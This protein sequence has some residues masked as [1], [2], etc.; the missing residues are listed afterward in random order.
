MAEDYPPPIP[1]P[2]PD[3]FFQNA[4][5]KSKKKK[6][7]SYKTAKKVLKSAFVKACEYYLKRKQLLNE[8]DKAVLYALYKQATV[9]D[10][11]E[12]T[13]PVLKKIELQRQ[14]AWKARTGLSKKRAMELYVENIGK[15][16][17][18][19]EDRRFET[20]NEDKSLPRFNPSERIPSFKEMQ[21]LV[22]RKALGN[23]ISRSPRAHQ[24]SA[25]DRR[26]YQSSI[27]E[28]EYKRFTLVKMRMADS[29]G[30]VKSGVHLSAKL[31]DG[32]PNQP[33]RDIVPIIRN[34]VAQIVV[35]NTKDSRYLDEFAGRKEPKITLN[36]YLFRLVRYLD[37]W[38]YDK[39]GMKSVG[40]RSILMSLVYLDRIATKILNFEITS[41]NV[42]RLFAVSMLLG[43][44]FSEDYIIANNYWAEV[45]GI[46]IDEL[47]ELESK[48]CSHLGFS[49]FVSDEEVYQ[50]YLKYT[51]L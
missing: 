10:C 42:H 19:F 25:E 33:Y 9:G 18:D 44:K 16:Y 13:Q 1:P 35:K 6:K 37:K 43:A 27:T 45:A 15:V 21:Q 39:P 38:F 40:F 36:D 23:G 51:H 46:S 8:E 29:L 41:L 14:L 17:P 47:N 49:L 26:S 31:P 34:V 11:P 5:L 50:Q 30:S 28:D 20:D 7:K 2:T 48:F 4:E 24:M 22:S 32:D 3:G 12:S